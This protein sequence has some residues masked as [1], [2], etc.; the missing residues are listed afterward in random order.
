MIR[1]PNGVVVA[2][3]EGSR[4]P[5]DAWSAADIWSGATG[6]RVSLHRL[7]RHL[8]IAVDGHEARIGPVTLRAIATALSQ[9]ADDIE[10]ELTAPTNYPPKG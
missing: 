2:F 4:R 5:V 10:R 8:V 7:K 1:H 3:N 6:E 9:A